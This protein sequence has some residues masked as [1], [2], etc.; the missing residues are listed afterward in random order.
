MGCGKGRGGAA[1]GGREMGVGEVEG[2]GGG[3]WKGLGEGRRRMC[4]CERA[5]ARRLEARG[6]P[7]QSAPAAAMT[8][9]KARAS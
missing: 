6:S 3:R 8:L 7:E 4:M 5:A 2:A 1:G 9:W